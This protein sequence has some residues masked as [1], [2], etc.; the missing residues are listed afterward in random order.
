[1]FNFLVMK[2]SYPT[3]TLLLLLTAFML[4]TS[5]KRD[6]TAPI[7]TLNGDDMQIALYSSYVEPGATAADLEDGDISSSIEITT[8]IDNNTLGDYSVTYTATDD[9]GNQAIKSRKVS[10]VM[11]QEN[12]VGNYSV[13]SSC[14]FPISI[15]GSQT[16]I[17]GEGNF[18]IKIGPIY[19]I[20]GG[21]L[22]GYIDGQNVLFP[23]QTVGLYDLTGT[24]T[25]NDDGDRLTLSIQFSA[26]LDNQ[27]CTLTYYK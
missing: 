25:M 19:N 9:A 17:P 8:T 18:G 2:L 27:T 23:T 26:L 15:D 10:V 7:I 5:C 13:T 20:I 14:G 3:S 4:F 1:M 6:K 12:Y 11:A 16:I 21:E 22:E 24:G